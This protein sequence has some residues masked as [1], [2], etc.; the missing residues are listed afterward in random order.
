MLLTATT[1][2]RPQVS[3]NLGTTGRTLVLTAGY[4][5][6]ALA[7][8]FLATIVA[9]RII[10]NR[11]GVGGYGA[12]ATVAAL[13]M[14]LPFADLGVGAA[15]V[16]ATSDYGQH[17]DRTK[18]L[19]T[20][21]A[22]VRLLAAAGSFVIA[23]DVCLLAFGAWPHLLG[24]G[25][26]AVP[27]LDVAAAA[28]IAGFGLALPSS[29]GYRMLQ[30]QGR[31]DLT[32]LFQIAVPLIST[33]GIVGFDLANLPIAF[34]AVCA[35]GASCIV[36]YTA[37]LFGIRRLGLTPRVIILHH[38]SVHGTYSRV[39]RLGSSAFVVTL[40]LAAAFQADRLI[41]SHRST[42]GQLAIY[43]IAAQIYVSVWSIVAMTGQNMWPHYRQARVRGQ[44]T[45]RTFLGHVVV[46]AALGSALGLLVMVLG[47]PVAA[48]LTGGRVQL[49]F[50][51]LLT[52]SALL[53]VQ[54]THL[55]AGML[56]TDEQGLRRQAAI[57][58]I[59]TA[60][61]LTLSWALSPS[62]GAVGPLLSSLITV[63]CF[64]L[65]V[66][67]WLGL[68]SLRGRSVAVA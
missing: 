40:G 51:L 46:A 66:T 23:L 5:A 44:L 41:L 43:S 30:G 13:P 33:I 64:Q 38:V 11:A 17:G 54:A 31:T 12:I 35:T 68:E 26:S 18:L 56:L 37:M 6:A 62:M 19:D 34:F 55:P 20:S 15:I 8:S 10:L 59:M 36:S 24:G 49:S 1:A 67:L 25:S 7:V 14:L 27:G 65:P 9:T 57:V 4:R 2:N 16:N 58:S 52:V 45:S 60:A 22:G 50:T 48:L 53:V 29:V 47:A 42:S 61:N 32:S 39:T 28:V 3:G 63:G 21:A